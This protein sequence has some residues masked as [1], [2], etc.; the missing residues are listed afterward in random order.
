M[1]IRFL[2]VFLLTLISYNLLVTPAVSQDPAP[3]WRTAGTAKPKL[4]TGKIQENQQYKSERGMFSVTV[5]SV[6]NFFTRD[7]KWHASQV[8][9]Q[10]YDYEEVVFS[11]ADS[12]E[13]YGAGIRRI[14]QEVLAQMAKAE[15][16]QTLSNLASK[17]LTE[18]RDDFAE[19]PR[20][21]EE[22]PVQT[23]FG[24]GL[25]RVYLAKHSSLLATVGHS[26][27]VVNMGRA[28]ESTAQKF[29]AYI[30]VLVVKQED[31]F[32]YT[33]AEDDFLQLGPGRLASRDHPLS[34]E[35]NKP[36]FDPQPD[37]RRTLQKF[38]ASIR[39]SNLKSVAPSSATQSPQERAGEHLNSVAF[40]TV[41][42]GCV[43]GFPGIILHT[44]DGG[45]T[46]AVQ[47]NGTD[48]NL[49]SVAFATPQL[50]WIVGYPGTILHTEDG[51]VTWT[52]QASGTEAR[53]ESVTFVTPL[54]GWAVGFFGTILH[55]EDGGH[56]WTKQSGGNIGPHAWL[57]SVVFATLQSGWAV[58]SDGI[59]LHTEDGGGN[60]KPQ[61][62]GTSA[63]L[64]SVVFATPQS[65][66][67]VGMGGTILHTDDGGGTWKPQASGTSVL[68][69][70]IAFTTPQ[71]GSAVGNGGTILHTVDG[72]GTWKP[73]VSGASELLYSLTFATP[74]SGWA[75]GQEGT[76]LH[77]ED[78]GGTWKK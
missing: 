46:W 51:G 42:S 47:A 21:V 77:T 32:V 69:R 76:I 24:G 20:A 17:A 57:Q 56:T 39:A 8:K 7:Y 5:P 27:G 11:I 28:G 65:G 70:S 31:W 78:G 60:W 26:G 53:L 33:T 71:S 19:E 64:T 6:S 52:P 72:G 49:L 55:T 29:D 45:N 68:L 61:V 14:P 74:Q 66:W 41:Q 4:R 54:S 37:L 44:A 9:D 15:G 23:Q 34:A 22:Y 75:V 13:A 40:A 58:G 35:S 18:W 30:A 2:Y 62:S 12:G 10:N 43:V 16:K 38:F 25:L 59:I 63:V 36:A 48:A 67:A 50:G 3:S 1:K 73:Q